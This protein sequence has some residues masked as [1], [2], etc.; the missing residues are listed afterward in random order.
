MSEL[1]VRCIDLNIQGNSTYSILK[2]LAEMAFRNGAIT[3]RQLFFTNAADAGKT[4]FYRIR[5]RYR[6]APWQKRL[7]R[8]PLCT[9]CP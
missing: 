2:Q 4:A 5:I 7:R 8:T 3:D 1:T 6:C 9:V